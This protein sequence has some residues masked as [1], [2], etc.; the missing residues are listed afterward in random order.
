MLVTTSVMRRWNNV[1]M[2]VH[3]PE[4]INSYTSLDRLIDN[5]G[6]YRVSEVAE[7]L[8]E[9]EEEIRNRRRQFDRLV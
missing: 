6:S 7:A 9:D 3:R 4:P 8:R 5:G 2:P 1:Q